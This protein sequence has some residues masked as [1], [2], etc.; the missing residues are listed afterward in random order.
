MALLR[1]AL[2]APGLNDDVAR[3][4]T[5]GSCKSPSSERFKGKV[6]LV[7]GASSGIG[8]LV[9]KA[10]ANDG[11]HVVLTAR[12]AEKLQAV[13]TEIESSGGSAS[14]EV[15]DVTKMDD[16][17]KVTAIIVEKLGRLDG[18]FNNAGSSLSQGTV[19]DLS[20]A[21]FKKTFELNFYGTYHCMKAQ[22]QVMAKQGFGSIV[23]NLSFLA[24]K[25]MAGQAHYG[26][27]KAALMYLQESASL[28]VAAQ[29]VRVNSVSPGFTRPSEAMDA[30]L[31][32]NP[33]MEQLFKSPMGAIVHAQAVYQAVAFLL[34]DV[35]SGSVT[36]VDLPVAGGHNVP[37][38]K[39]G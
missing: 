7:T 20:A 31:A 11:A 2:A 27:S 32:T 38:V 25:H 28:E 21:D 13:K 22:L 14:V 6:F 15:L 19:V 10:L 12:R 18:A 3:V 9:A 36:G 5:S 33:G 29:G 35:T 24:K 39:L 16:V 17:E 37:D 34:D 8:E 1:T 23:N 4:C 26:A 30:F